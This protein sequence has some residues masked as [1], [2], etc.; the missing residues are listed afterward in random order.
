MR[1]HYAYADEN[2]ELIEWRARPDAP[3]RTVQRPPPYAA[4][5]CLGLRKD[6]ST[7]ALRRPRRTVAA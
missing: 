3:P 1:R 7:V 6:G 5:V 2:E 4:T